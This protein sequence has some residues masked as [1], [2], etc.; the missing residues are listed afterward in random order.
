MTD[1]LMHT[2]RHRSQVLKALLWITLIGGLFFSVVNALNGNNLL[3]ALELTYGAISAYMLRIIDRTHRLQLLTTIY[4]VPFFSIM[5]LAIGQTETIFAV[6]AWIQTIPIICYML[7]GVRLGMLSSVV[8]VSIGLWA[9]SQ[10]YWA[11][12]WL[13]N[14][15]IVTNLGLASLLIMALAHI[16]ERSRLINEKRLTELATTDALTGLANRVKLAEVFERER[17]HALRNATPLS[18]VFLD[19]DHFKQI[20]D[21]FGHEVGDRALTHFAKTLS[22]RLRVN[23]LL[24]RLGG[25][26]FAV[27][28]PSSTTQL[29]HNIAENL[30]E[31]LAQ[32][33]LGLNDEVLPMTLSAGIAELGKDGQTLDELLLTADQRTYA[34]KR[35]GRNQVVAWDEQPALHQ[36]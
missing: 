28:L 31:R 1:P 7:L 34:A 35:A 17:A 29:A 20:N 10:R 5:I 8:F 25:E 12:N 16:Y 19:V 21:R 9:F 13:P 14:L 2:E 4:L 30:R 15:E 23:D 36:A 3:A 33:P 26:E 27:L 18:L 24:C 6:F 22:Q 32:E 11:G